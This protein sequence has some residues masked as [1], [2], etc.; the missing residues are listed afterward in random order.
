MWERWTDR[1]SKKRQIKKTKHIYIQS[2]G[3]KENEKGEER[4][5][6]K[7]LFNCKYISLKMFDVLSSTI[8]D[9]HNCFE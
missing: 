3:Q 2:K 9:R 7:I 8:S 5:R 4:E 6:N 1:S